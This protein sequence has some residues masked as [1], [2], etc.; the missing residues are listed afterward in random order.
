M[1]SPDWKQLASILIALASLAIPFWLWQFDLKSSSIA[2]RLVA[3]AALV[4]ERHSSIPD[5]KLIIGDKEIAAPQL[6]N[7][8]ITNNGFKPIPTSNFESPIEI[9]VTANSKLIRASVLYSSPQDLQP[10]MRQ[11]GQVVSISPLLLNPGDSITLLF[12]TSGQRPIISGRARIAGVQ[13]IELE[14]ATKKTSQLK[15]Y[16][17][18]FPAA[19]I[20]MLLYFAFAVELIHPGHFQ[21]SRPI[22]SSV[23]LTG[24]LTGFTFLRRAIESLGLN[25]NDGYRTA[26][27]I[28][29]SAIGFIFVIYLRARRKS[30]Y[31]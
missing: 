29:M 26:F 6:L 24:A 27:V 5:L 12:I 17:L 31:A 8:E 18:Y 20:G 30:G 3:S 14:D 9:E 4:P 11:I 16:G 19:I 22:A 25:P 1:P 10:K 2:I 15:A 28:A 7:I 21:I 23:M 13:K